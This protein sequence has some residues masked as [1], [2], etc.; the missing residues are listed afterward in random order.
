MSDFLGHL[1]ARSLDLSPAAAAPAVR[2]RLASRFEPVTPAASPPV[3]E[4]VEEVVMP[5][6]PAARRESERQDP[7][8]LTPSP[9]RPPSSRPERERGN[10]VA[11]IVGEDR[12]GGGAPLPLGVGAGGRAGEGLG[13]RAHG[14][15]ATS[16]S[17][18]PPQAGPIIK[19]LHIEESRRRAEPAPPTSPEPAHRA[20]IPVQAAASTAPPS[21]ERRPQIEP[22]VRRLEVEKVFI[23]TSAPPPAP[24]PTPAVPAQAG[25]VKAEPVP[26]Q[27]PPVLQPRVPAVERTPFPARRDE[28]D[29]KPVIHV[30]IGRIEV[31]ATQAPKAPVR[32]RQAARPAVDL[33]EYLRQR[34][35]G[36][37]R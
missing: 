34:A 24:V 26:V 4:T 13:E 8:P 29:A 17:Q 36:D 21:P 20:P 12:L 18:T 25:P 30:T 9:V 1:V 3:E 19:P 31:R 28:P 10:A 14:G 6:A 33:E 11:A 16:T 23:P 15:P 27:A 22:I 35:Q 2:P 32:E 7:H 5:A 37:R